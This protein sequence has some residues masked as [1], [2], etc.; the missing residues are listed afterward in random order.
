MGSCVS[1]TS[2]RQKSK[3]PYFCY[4]NWKEKAFIEIKDTKIFTNTLKKVIKIKQNPA[5]GYL[6]NQRLMVVGGKCASKLKINFGY[7]LSTDPRKIVEISRLPYATEGGNLHEYD[8][9]VYYIGGVTNDNSNGSFEDKPADFMRYNL[10]NNFWEIIAPEDSDLTLRDKL[11][12]KILDDDS[13]HNNIQV[14]NHLKINKNLKTLKELLCPGT[15]LFEGFIY[16]IGGKFIRKESFISSLVFKIDLKTFLITRLNIELPESIYKPICI[17]YGENIILIGGFNSESKFVYLNFTVVPNKSQREM[18]LVSN[19]PDTLFFS[20]FSGE[21]LIAVVSSNVYSLSKNESQWT[22]LTTKN[23]ASVDFKIQKLPQV[24]FMTKPADL[25]LELPAQPITKTNE[26]LLKKKI[27]IPKLN[28]EKAISPVK[29][30]SLVYQHLNK[31]SKPL[32]SLIEDDKKPDIVLPNNPGVY[33]PLPIVCNP[34][35]P[36]TISSGSSV[37]TNQNIENS[38][39]QLGEE[40]K[41]HR[42]DKGNSFQP[43]L[44]GSIIPKAYSHPYSVESI[45]AKNPSNHMGLLNMDVPVPVLPSAKPDP[46]E[47]ESIISSSSGSITNPIPVNKVMCIDNPTL[48]I[49]NEKDHQSS[50]KITSPQYIC[51]TNQIKKIGETVS[52]REIIKINT[53]K[54]LKN[55]EIES[56]EPMPILALKKSRQPANKVYSI[57]SSNSDDSSSDYSSSSSH[58]KNLYKKQSEVDMDNSSYSSSSSD[59]QIL[60]NKKSD[61]DISNSPKIDPGLVKNFQTSEIFAKGPEGYLSSSKEEN[62]ILITTEETKKLITTVCTSLEI[63]K[64]PNHVISE[65]IACSKI[66]KSANLN[67][68]QFLMKKLLP[69]KSFPLKSLNKF[70]NEFQTQIKL[71]QQDFLDIISTAQIR[72][73]ENMIDKARSVLCIA[74]AIKYIKSKSSP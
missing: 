26:V 65:L 9:W 43:K 59:I 72:S 20:G 27:V 33:G 2:K 68:I 49:K 30:N 19:N 21:N 69:D 46:E 63:P 37:S 1:K 53:I 47:D 51:S 5:I 16:V 64:C 22:R 39:I 54:I 38:K 3:I 73:A 10:E 35:R 67:Q 34:D 17:K 8:G 66:T 41:L 6:S 24:Q 36:D 25:L 70:V 18:P 62:K 60:Y 31:S 7:I 50:N 56:K 55:S 57:S 45:D 11:C 40:Q 12:R 15:V 44:M 61:I 42:N 32:K 71:T 23:K 14:K 28:I 4:L 58:L 13:Y 74:S 48:C 29:I 52:P